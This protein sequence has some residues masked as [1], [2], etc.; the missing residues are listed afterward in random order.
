MVKIG[1][2]IK[3]LNRDGQYTKWAKKTWVVNHI[4]RSEGRGKGQHPGYDNAMRGGA[5]VDCIGLPVSLYEYEFVVVKSKP[6][7]K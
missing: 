7:K 6:R 2:T 3:I 1:D 4:A 5:L